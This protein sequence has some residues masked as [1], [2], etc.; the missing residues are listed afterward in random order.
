MQKYR[1]SDTHF[2][3]STG[4]GYNDTG[5]EVLE[6]VYAEVF[7]AEAALVRHQITCGTHALAICLYGVL[8]PGDELL[9]VTG[10]SYDTLE[11]IIGIRGKAGSGSLKDYGV[12][13]RQVELLE[14]GEMDYDPKVPFQTKPKWFFAKITRLCLRKPITAEDIET[15]VS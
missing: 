2:N 14:D 9:S 3:S 1:V 10:R 8:R 5:R 11:E 4:Y 13:Y 15:P 12:S 7:G 6:Q